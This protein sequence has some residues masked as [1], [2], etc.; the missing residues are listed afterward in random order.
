[1]RLLG[2]FV[3]RNDVLRGIK[4]ATARFGEVGVIGSI[5][6]V[7]DSVVGIVRA[8]ID[9]AFEMAAR[10]NDVPIADLAFNRERGL[11]PA[12][13]VER[14]EEVRDDKV[15]LARIEKERA[16]GNLML[17]NDEQALPSNCHPDRP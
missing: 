5:G 9:L 11:I 16:V 10:I 8:A 14:R 4:E 3:T 1:M 12:I 6:I 15:T 13:L 7:S 17:V 2:I